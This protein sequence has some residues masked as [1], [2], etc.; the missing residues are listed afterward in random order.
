MP[1]KVVVQMLNNPT[2]SK[3]RDMKLKTMAEMFSNENELSSDLSFEERF[4]LMVEREWEHKRNNKIQRYIRNAGFG[5]NAY[6]EDVDYGSH[7]KIDKDTIKKLSTCN[8][9]EQK[10]NILVSG[11]TGAGKSY[12]ACAFGNAACR[13]GYQ[14]K[15]YRVPELLIELKSVKSEGK[16]NGFMSKLRKVSLLILD[17][18]GI[19]SYEQEEARDLLELAESRYN[20]ASTIFVSQI[21][22]DKWYELFP[23]PTLADAFM[24][25]IIHNSYMIPLDS[26]VSMREISAEKTMKMVDKMD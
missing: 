10:L 5:V 20:I 6:L 19:K 12:L 2:V 25:R 17:D 7:R 21:P 11:K 23:D 24:D 14:V 26:K 15:Y 8:Y 4:S 13:H 9:I 1:S 3:L 16:Y 22:H 18:I